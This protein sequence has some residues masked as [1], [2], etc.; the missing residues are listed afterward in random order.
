[1][2]VNDYERRNEFEQEIIDKLDLSHERE[3]VLNEYFRV[4]ELE[5]SITEMKD[6]APGQDGI[7]PKLI[8]QLPDSAIQYLLDLFNEVWDS[9][10][11]PGQ[12]LHSILIPVFKAG[13][14]PSNPSSYRSISLSPVLCKLME[15]MVKNRLT[16]FI[17][18][19]DI[20]TPLQWGFRKERSTVDQIIR[21][22]TDVHKALLNK[23]YTIVLV[24]DL[25]KAYD[26]L[27]RKGIVCTK[28]G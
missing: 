1:M 14:D 15:R 8:G 12:W 2:S 25:E 7:L 17:E 11:L 22:E 21:L 28:Q 23:E 10:I 9:S 5:K 6:S 4:T 13:R 20:I 27:W 19:Y 3:S 24:L 18:K 16:W 26:V